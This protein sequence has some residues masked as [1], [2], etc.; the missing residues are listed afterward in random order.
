MD[1]WRRRIGPSCSWLVSELGHLAQRFTA[2][3][4]TCRL[5][6]NTI[7]RF[8]SCLEGAYAVQDAVTCYESLSFLGLRAASVGIPKYMRG[9]PTRA[10][11]LKRRIPSCAPFPTRKAPTQ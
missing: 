9:V 11:L 2:I 4:F 3:A 5:R 8:R 1:V 10:I 7:S 6:L